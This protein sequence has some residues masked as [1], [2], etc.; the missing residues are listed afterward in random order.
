MDFV[1]KENALE[2]YEVN[3]EK[4]NEIVSFEGNA[5]LFVSFDPASREEKVKLLNMISGET[6]AL[7]EH[8][9]EEIEIVDVAVMP[10]ELENDDH[11]KSVT[12]RCIIAG[13]N[14][15][16]YG[17]TSWGLYKGLQRVYHIFGSLH[18][19]D[20]LKIKVEMVKTKKGKT[21]NLKFI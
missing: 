19:D 6:E 5:S 14:G 9:N 1:E 8:T 13:A 15:V 10:V 20:P 3:R 17:A 4:A 21:F 18:F 2:I 7:A 16:N 11:T 12:P